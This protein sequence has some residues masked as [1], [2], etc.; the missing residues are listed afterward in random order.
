MDD[1]VL[2][3]L[4]RWPNVPAVYGWLQLDR[5]GTWLLQGDPVHNR[6]VSDYIG[7]NYERE[8]D[9]RWFFQNGPQRVYVELEYTPLVYRAVQAPGA[10]LA[11]EAHTRSSARALAGAWID[12]RGALIVETELGPGV[13]HDADLAAVLPAFVDETGAPLAEDALAAATDRLQRQLEAPL[14]LSLG[15]SR[16]RVESIL[17]DQLPDRLGFVAKPGDRETEGHPEMST[18]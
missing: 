12:N 6:V 3:G 17:A 1:Q 7:R 8:P 5:R 13:V 14:W 11:L 18:K 16:V 4:A 15:G 2:R 9:G 10:P